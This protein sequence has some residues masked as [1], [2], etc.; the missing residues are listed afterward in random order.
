MSEPVV[1]YEVEE[2]VATV[3]LNRPHRLNAW[4]GRMD[5]AL[6]QALA[7][8]EHDPEVRAIVLTGAGRGFCAGADSKALDRHA[9]AG[10]YDSGLPDAPATPG[11]GVRAD[12]DHPYAYLLGIPKPV[13]A[14]VN[15]PAAG[16][17]L[18]LACF[19]DVRFAA[20]GAKLTTA[21]ARLGLPAEYGMSWILP[22]LIGAGRAAEL[23][24][25]SRIV[26]AEE[27]ERMGLVNRV[28]PPE[29]LLPET[30]VF[31]RSLASDVS[32]SSLRESKRQLW[33]DLLRPLD[34]AMRDAVALLDRMVQEP[35]FRE[36]AAALSE[37]RPPRF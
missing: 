25:S 18:V 32:P 37:K 29:R 12:F 14:A 36:G 2:R 33:S 24:F 19:C 35:D 10:T 28:L 30:L 7:D 15:G 8:A 6:R 31:A 3:T 16:V 21:N 9:D 22:R 11:H 26:L 17:G 1:L 5:A 13:I 23:L 27:A 4:T 34:E 20:E